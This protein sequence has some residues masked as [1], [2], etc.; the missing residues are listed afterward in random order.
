MLGRVW[1][2]FGK[3]SSQLRLI[4]GSWGNLKDTHLTP[5]PPASGFVLADD[6]LVEQTFLG[7]SWV[8]K[9]IHL[10][11]R[12]RLPCGQKRGQL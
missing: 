8:Q 1:P 3:L 11:F 4:H 2:G 12:K 9:D 7:S 5:P 6:L 10:S